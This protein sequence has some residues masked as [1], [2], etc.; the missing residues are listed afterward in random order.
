MKSGADL[1]DVLEG[2]GQIRRLI[3]GGRG[4]FQGAQQL[5]CWKRPQT[6]TTLCLLPMFFKMKQIIT[7]SYSFQVFLNRYLAPPN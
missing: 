4:P 1:E 7:A 3:E 2:K 5:K 6:W